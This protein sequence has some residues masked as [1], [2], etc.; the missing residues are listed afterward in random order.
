MSKCKLE[1]ISGIELFVTEINFVKVIKNIFDL[2]I[3]WTAFVLNHLVKFVGSLFFV[4][5]AA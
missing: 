2:W 4:L 3:Y 1:V 5:V